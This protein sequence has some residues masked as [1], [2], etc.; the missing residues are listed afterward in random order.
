[1]KKMFYMDFGVLDMMLLT[2]QPFMTKTL[3]MVLLQY[4]VMAEKL[5]TF[6][7]ITVYLLIQYP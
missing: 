7:I 5:G 6:Y 4:L 2:I 3:Q 1:M